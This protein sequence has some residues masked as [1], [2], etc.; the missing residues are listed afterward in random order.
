MA[1][2]F[3]ILSVSFFSFFIFIIIIFYLKNQIVD[4]GVPFFAFN[5]FCAFFVVENVT[6][7][8]YCIIQV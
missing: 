5:I 4:F 6:H 7:G 1:Y 2:P 8:T 3:V